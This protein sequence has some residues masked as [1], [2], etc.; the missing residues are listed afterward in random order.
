MG[1]NIHRGTC[2][3]FMTVFTSVPPSE[4]QKFRV[5]EVNSSSFR[6]CW[7]KPKYHGSP[8]LAGYVISYNDT[9]ARIGVVG[10]FIFDSDRLEWRQ[11]YS[12]AVSAVSEAVNITVRGSPSRSLTLIMGKILCPNNN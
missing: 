1:R 6:V 3:Q 8:Y 9:P 10:C 11:T 7:D 5:V 2:K 12:I 4:P